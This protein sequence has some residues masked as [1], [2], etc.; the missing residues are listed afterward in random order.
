M[1]KNNEVNQIVMYFDAIGL[2][3]FVLSDAHFTNS[4]N[5]K[6]KVLNMHYSI[7]FFPFQ[8]SIENDHKESDSSPVLMVRNHYQT[9]MTQS[10]SLSLTN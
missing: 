1:L 10:H 2:W 9:D 5:C 4:G 8:L 7:F 3:T 6:M